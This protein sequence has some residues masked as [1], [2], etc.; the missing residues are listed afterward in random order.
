[1]AD[2]TG[3]GRPEVLYG[4]HD[5]Y[6][7]C[8][9]PRANPLWQRDI[10]HGRALMYPSEIMAADLN[11]DDVPELILTTF[12]DPNNIVPGVPHG[13][14]MIL[15]NLGQVL[16]DIQ[17]PEQGTNGNGKGAPA[18]PT[19]M[20]LTGDGTLE[21]VVQTFGVGCFVFSVPGSAENR[22]L[23]PTGRGNYLRDGR[24]WP[25]AAMP[26]RGDI[27]Q[28]RDIDLADAVLS[29]QVAAGQNPA[30]IG[31]TGDVD[32]DGRLGTGEASYVLQVVSR[33][34]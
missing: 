1:V 33:L 7:Y 14:L 22:L 5:G 4:A 27:D 12:G 24:P 8:I 23:W 25:G 32:G 21:I 28:D 16:F 31:A 11:Q 3:D 34:R 19:V 20:D 17:L 2:I 29:L 26:L 6:V 10:R 30:G 9:G 18:A 13:Y 15:D